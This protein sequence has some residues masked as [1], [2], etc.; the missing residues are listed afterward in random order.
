MTFMI[1]AALVAAVAL[2]LAGPA[3]AQQSVTQAD[4]QRLQDNVFQTE[5]DINQMPTRDSARV[6]QLR[7]DL[8]DLRD[9]VI[10]L[11]V[12][13]RKDRNVTRPSG[14]HRGSPQPHPRRC[15]FPV[16][17]RAAGSS[18]VYT[19]A[20]AGRDPHPAPDHGG[21]Q[22]D[23]GRNGVGCAAAEQPQLRDRPGRRSF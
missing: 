15:I 5:R 13:L 18:S 10:Y 2:S 16:H 8:D 23:P 20:C 7:D 14:S 19:A 11:K 3:V 21:R 12:K 9:E 22:R 6:A 1:R 17:C 4:I